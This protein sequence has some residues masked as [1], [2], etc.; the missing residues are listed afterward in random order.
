[1]AEETKVETKTVKTETPANIEK[2]DN[3]KKFA[4]K[5]VNRYSK[6]ECKKELGR[7]E[8]LGSQDSKYYGDVK[9]RLQKA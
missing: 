9:R 7:L 6:E 5:K 1:M 3:S 2:T 4:K 8:N